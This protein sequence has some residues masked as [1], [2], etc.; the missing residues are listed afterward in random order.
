MDKKQ[1]RDA[2]LADTELQQI[3]F[4]GNDAELARRISV[5]ATAEYRLTSEGLLD[6]FGAMRGGE[7]MA[8][9]RK[10]SSNNSPIGRTLAEVVRML[11]A[12][13]YN[14]GHRD[15]DLVIDQL[16]PQ[17]MTPAEA[18]ALKALPIKKTHPSARDVSKA[19]R[20]WR[21]GGRAQQLV[22]GE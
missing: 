3:A 18:A 22:T 19:L 1:I 11:D 14:I 16:V 9:I 7:I 21:P 6:V 17:V 4:D 20:K 10:A 2:I 15:A 8:A 5:N 13:G 12:G